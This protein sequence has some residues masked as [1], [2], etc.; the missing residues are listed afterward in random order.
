[1]KVMEMARVLEK[2]DLQSGEMS[3]FIFKK[4]RELVRE[5]PSEEM[6]R[7]AGVVRLAIS[8]VVWVRAV[9]LAKRDEEQWQAGFLHEEVMGKFC[10]CM[11]V[12]LRE[13]RSYLKKK[14]R[15]P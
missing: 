8:G 10:R 15:M 9:R 12:V 4:C 11:I 2:P 6:E 13:R 1:M 14:W 7:R 3:S 5:W